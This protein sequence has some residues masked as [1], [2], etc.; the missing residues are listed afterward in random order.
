MNVSEWI[1]K[2]EQEIGHPIYRRIKVAPA[3]E[4]RFPDGTIIKEPKRPFGERNTSTPDEIK[5]FRGYKVEDF[6]DFSLYL[7]HM[8]D[9]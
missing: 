4:K 7:K 5:A 6:T 3:T 1:E 8:P 9:C 2:Q